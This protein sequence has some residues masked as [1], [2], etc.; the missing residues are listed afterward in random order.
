MKKTTLTILGG[1]TAGWL[2][3][4][5]LAKGLPKDRF[6][7]CLVENPDMPSVGVGEATI[8]PFT[9][10]LK[11]LE[12]E[13][14]CFLKRLNGTFKYGIQFEDW[15][16]IGSRYMHAFG[17][18][19][20]PLK[21]PQD[22][23]HCELP[24]TQAW[25]KSANTLKLNEV[26]SYIPSA[27]A[28]QAGK[29][30]PPVFPPKDAD[31]Q[32][33]YPLS[34]LFYAYQFDATQLVDLLKDYAIDHSID[35]IE[36]MVCR[37]N[38]K[39]DGNISSLSLG[40]GRKIFG[41][42][43]IDC[44]GF[45]SRL[46]KM[47][48]RCQFDDWSNELPCDSAIAVQTKRDTPAP[49]FTKSIAMGSG[50]R[51]QIPLRNRTGNGYVYASQF[52]S[53]EEALAELKKTLTGHIFLTQPK[54]LR[55][56]TG[57]LKMPWFRNSIAIG[58]AS[59]FMEPLES[60]SIHLIHKYALEL[61]DALLLGQEMPL[62]A[63]RFNHRF[64]QEATSIK[65][66]LLAHYHVTNR[67]DTPF[68]Q[69]CKNMPITQTLKTYLAEFARTGYITLPNDSLFPFQSWFQVLIGQGYLR[70]Y[71]AFEDKQFDAKQVEP[72]FNNV[73]LAI[74][75]EVARLALHQSYLE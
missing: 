75:S 13:E 2:S 49:A 30:H 67:T 56:K 35:H 8:P 46:N 20:T 7:I 69:H 51:W 39:R 59:G 48:Y 58:L 16:E 5:I 50:W 37:V 28:A 27:V 38:N 34:L 6:H 61:K 3:A 55:F 24:F 15:S 64:Y 41:D 63:Q 62:E 44:S 25:L 43:F 26:A 42:Y 60:T 72:F 18:I 22:P 52:I 47:H 57:C 66:F 36:G 1:G 68:W 65:D 11:Y 31:P 29:F 70:D 21:T 17:K 14:S 32:H 54:I 73:K 74:Q 19:G 40:D 53:D 12:I 33:F 23:H 9:S 4:A 71:S 45:Q 10:L